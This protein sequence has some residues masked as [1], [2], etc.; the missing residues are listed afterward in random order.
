LVKK[1]AKMRRPI[2]FLSEIILAIRKMHVS[3]YYTK[4]TFK[5]NCKNSII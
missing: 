4:H 3:I 5:Q 2:K 1:V